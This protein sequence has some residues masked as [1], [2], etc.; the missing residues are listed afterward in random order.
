[1]PRNHY[2]CQKI[3]SIMRLLYLMAIKIYH[4]L[5]CLVAPFHRK[6]RLFSSGRRGSFKQL[7]KNLSGW[8][9]VIWFHCASLGEFEQGR[10]LIELIRRNDPEVKILL[11]FFSPSGY[12]VRKNYSKADCVAY[13]PADTPHNA[14]RFIT[15]ANP[16]KVFFIKYEYWYFFLKELHRKGIPTYLV[17]ALFRKEQ[18]FFRWYGRWFR[19][20]LGFYS[21]IFVQD[22]ASKKLLQD[23]HTDHVSVSG[24]TR[25]DRV[26]QVSRSAPSLPLVEKFAGDSL[27][28]VA[29]STWPADEK[30]LM[31]YFR[32][33]GFS[34]KMILAPH[35][36]HPSNIQRIASS[37][38]PHESVTWSAASEERL[39][40]AR[41]LIID[42]IG[43]LSSL[44][45]YGRLAY[46]GGGF[47][48]GIHNILEAAAYS[49]PVVF[50]PNHEK[51]KEALDLKAR[52][53]AFAISEYEDL[54]T[55]LDDLLSHPEKMNNA[56]K[57]A[58]SY[59]DARSG[60]VEHL[61]SEIFR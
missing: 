21:H 42:S 10:P 3:R 59:V 17:S 57:I 5:V 34:F 33:S 1:M 18:V 44:Y 39:Q 22:E 51:F 23:N 11:T 61:W 40:K 50:G 35:E 7:E 26:K 28:L 12:E 2:F 43:M 38:S 24:D 47:G 6:A 48:K 8:K 4:W 31:H 13:L 29:G 27:L 32:E 60:A 19:R 49:I 46:V 53:G 25:F 20:M 30:F 37:F 54:S 58:G 36:V 9:R 16:E 15:I 14:R 56:G 45:G 52:G 41:I 55:L